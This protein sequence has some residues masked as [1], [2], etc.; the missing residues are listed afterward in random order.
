MPRFVKPRIVPPV[1]VVILLF[2][3][4]VMAT[5][6]GSR[7][8]KLEA[9]IKRAMA[10]GPAAISNDATIV[11]IGADGKVT[12]LRPGNNGWIC[13]PG[14]PGME[15]HDAMCFDP[16]AR[17]W[18]TDLL[19]HKPKPTNTKPGVLYMLSGGTDWSSTDPWAHGGTPIPEPPHWALLW[20]FD[21]KE[22]GLPD[23]PQSTG[24]WIM[25]AGTPYAHLMVNQQP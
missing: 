8:E 16:A 17:Q 24:T 7:Q 13:M 19:A 15:G 3:S 12:V 9:K 25:Y 4:N 5:R 18:L 6:P 11:E 1:V 20:P 10:A 14:H 21:P 23:T 22:T 2:V